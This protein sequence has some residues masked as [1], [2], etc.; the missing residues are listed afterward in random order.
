[1]TISEPRAK[2][3]KQEGSEPRLRKDGYWQT[4]YVAGYQPSGQANLKSAYGKTKAECTHKLREALRE[5]HA[6]QTT[7]GLKPRLIKWLDS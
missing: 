6:G 2:R 4:N 3:G 1:M 5:V 7:V